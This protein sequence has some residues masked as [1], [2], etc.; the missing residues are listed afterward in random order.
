[1][2]GMFDRK[3]I[4]DDE[5]RCWETNEGSACVMLPMIPKMLPK[6]TKCFSAVENLDRSPS[7]S[8]ALWVAAPKVTLWCSTLR[9]EDY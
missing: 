5:T 4:E 6:N 1:M 9:T 2:A 8:A 3:P 7:L